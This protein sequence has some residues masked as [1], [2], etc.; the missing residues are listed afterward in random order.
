VMAKSTATVQE[1]HL[2]VIHMLCE[3]IEE[4]CA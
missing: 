4:A 3:V 2:A 1:V